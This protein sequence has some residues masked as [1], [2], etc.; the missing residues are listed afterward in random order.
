MA[1]LREESARL[2]SGEY[3]DSWEKEPVF[4]RELHVNGSHPAASDENDGSIDHP[5]KTISAAAAIAAPGT[6]VLIHAGTYRETVKPARGGE[7]PEKM[8]SYEAFGDGDAI[9]KA[10]IVT[11]AYEPSTGW[12]LYRRGPAP[13]ADQIPAIWQVKLD[14]DE[15]RGYN[16]FCA[17]NILHDRLFIEYDKTDMT[18]YLNRRGM[19][20]V[21][22]KPL[23]QVQLPG[24]MATMP[25]SYWIEANGQ[26]VH[27]RMPQDDDPKDHVIELTC[28]EQCFAPDIPYLEYI[29]VKGLIC[30]HAATGAP[31]PQRGAISCYRGNHWI[32]EDCTIDWSNCIGIDIGSECWH[33]KMT[34]DHTFG[35][36]II[37]RNK[38]C[39]AGVCG[40]AGMMV[41]GTLIEDNLIQGT[42]WQKM[43]LSWEAGAIKTH[44]SADSLIRRNIFTKT[45]RCDALWFDGTGGNNR[46]TQNLFLDG[47]EGREAI[48][49]EA[50]RSGENMF[51]NN[52][53]W[54][55]QGRFNEADVPQ[56]A[57]S[58]PW[59]NLGGEDTIVN[60]YGIYGEG[61]DY[62]RIS[63]N[64]IGNCRSTGY[65][66]RTV[67]FRLM[68]RGGT[69]REAKIYNNLFYNCGEAA[70]KF[71]TKDNEA[72][73]NVYAGMMNGY[74]RVLF[75]LPTMCLD[76]KAW[77]EFLGFDKTGAAA[78]FVIDVDTD[79]YTLTVRRNTT[80]MPEMMRR[81]FGGD[82]ISDPEKLPLVEADKKIGIDFFGNDVGTADRAAGP[83]TKLA[84]GITF[85]IDPRKLYPQ[86]TKKRRCE[87]LQCRFIPYFLIFMADKEVGDALPV[88]GREAVAA[89]AQRE[90]DR[91]LLEEVARHRITCARNG[92]RTRIDKARQTQQLPGLACSDGADHLAVRIAP[93][94]LDGAG[95]EHLAR[96]KRRDDE[97]RVEGH[98]LLGIRIF[99]EVLGEP[100]RR[101]IHDAAHGLADLAAQD[102][103]AAAA[104]ADGVDELE[105]LVVKARRQSALSE[106]GAAGHAEILHV[107]NA[108]RL[109]KVRDQARCDA[110]QHKLAA[111]G[112]LTAVRIDQRAYAGGE[113]A[114]VCR[115]VHDR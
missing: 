36:D 11:T 100:E 35:C 1:A 54:N 75:P 5:F 37:R 67:A 39:D 58:A 25:G 32:I 52:V 115:A 44:G 51:D 48:F 18:T 17:V 114:V 57:G 110:P 60:G 2:P 43:E 49:V 68:G 101:V 33:R 42:G 107:E 64:L 96:G 13:A 55:V 45:I 69:S 103:A 106:A 31:V 108:Q 95:Q 97:V 23:Y 83:F 93:E 82:R 86:A 80:P 15:F 26:T 102:G 78:D 72:E 84:D 61:T 8:I 105:A 88:V 47:I 113:I 81:F 22:G 87:N 27:F 77:Q 104:G 16:P 92:V 111:V 109:H 59:Y 112:I 3:F 30:A 65:Y 74:L 14:P 71:P 62:L 53:I 70:I 90:A 89:R 85:S 9:I 41:Q 34:P 63:N 76:L 28:R 66:Q 91:A 40:I 29:R 50:S 12:N 56:V 24:Q 10:S 38:I 20:F 21:D 6:K 79:H 4:D 19:V 46:V 99:A 94:I 98:G 73:G 7:S